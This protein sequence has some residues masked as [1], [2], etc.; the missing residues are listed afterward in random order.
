MRKEN[1]TVARFPSFC[2]ASTL[3]ASES[4]TNG[5]GRKGFVA[6]LCHSLYKGFKEIKTFGEL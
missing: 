6:F 2:G 5:S 1:L 3:G 4:L